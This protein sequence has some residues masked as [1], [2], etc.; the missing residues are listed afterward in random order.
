LIWDWSS[1]SYKRRAPHFANGD[2][3]STTLMCASK[4]NEVGAGENPVNPTFFYLKAELMTFITEQQS[5][6]A[7]I[8]ECKE[9]QEIDKRILKWID[10]VGCSQRKFQRYDRL[11]SFVKMASQ[12]ND[13]YVTVKWVRDYASD[14][15][16]EIGE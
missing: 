7:K 11:L 13:K 3:E 10:H 16:K 5:T 15:L 12:L 9:C 4:P 8:S 14:L 6:D 2:A 1:K